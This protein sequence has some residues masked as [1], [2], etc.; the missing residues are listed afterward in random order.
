[1]VLLVAV[2]AVV[3]AEMLVLALTR[4]GLALHLL[5]VLEVLEAALQV[6]RCKVELVKAIIL[7]VLRLA[8]AVMAAAMLLHLLL[9]AAAAAILA[10]AAVVLMVLEAAVRDML[11]RQLARQTR[12]ALTP[13][14]QLV[15]L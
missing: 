1:V 2:L 5:E 6:V 4:A 15:V 14:A 7:A 10:A 13:Q 3:L 9:A 12:Q 11:E 8:A